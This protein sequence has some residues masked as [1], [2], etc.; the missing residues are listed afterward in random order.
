M[1]TLISTFA[2]IPPKKQ[3]VKIRKTDADNDRGKT[4]KAT[5]AQDCQKIQ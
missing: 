2:I 1:Y 4:V 3:V 5:L